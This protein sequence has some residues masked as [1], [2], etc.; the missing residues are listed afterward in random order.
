M[1]VIYYVSDL[2]QDRDIREKTK[3]VIQYYERMYRVKLK[4]NL[5]EEVVDDLYKKILKLRE[6]A[7]D[8]YRTGYF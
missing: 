5:P 8:Y 7:P 1:T 2:F 4:S 6:E 3:I